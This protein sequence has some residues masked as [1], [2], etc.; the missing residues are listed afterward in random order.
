MERFSRGVGPVRGITPVARAAVRVDHYTYVVNF[1][2]LNP[3][4]TLPGVINIEEDA[5]FDLR[6]L[7][8][9]AYAGATQTAASRL[10]PNVRVQFFTQDSRRFMSQAVALPA[11]FGDGQNVFTLPRARRFGR[12]TNITW[13]VTNNDAGALTSLQILMIGEKV[14]DAD[15]QETTR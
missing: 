12:R 15:T 11:L 8:F 9:F 6:A 2:V 4:A 7:S 10:L 14:F 3:G 1:G 5:A 13:E